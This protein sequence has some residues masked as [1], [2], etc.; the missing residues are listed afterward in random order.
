MAPKQSFIEQGC[1][2]ERILSRSRTYISPIQSKSHT[3]N[4]QCNSVRASTCMSQSACIISLK[5]RFRGSFSAYRSSESVQFAFLRLEKVLDA[6]SN[7]FRALD[8][9]DLEDTDTDLF[10]MSIRDRKRRRHT[11][12]RVL[13]KS[14]RFN[15]SRECNQT[16]LQL[17]Y[18]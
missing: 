7:W 11:S 6:R 9:F 4:V 12:S 5:A 2:S 15:R 18:K 10:Y 14:R 8:S 13:W 3:G 17:T 16:R 1:T